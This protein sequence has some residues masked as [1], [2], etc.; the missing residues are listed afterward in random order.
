[1][2]RLSITVIMAIILLCGGSSFAAS[3]EEVINPFNPELEHNQRDISVLS[4]ADF[5][6]IWNAHDRN[7]LVPVLEWLH[8]FGSGLS[9]HVLPFSR[10]YVI[11]ITTLL[12]NGCRGNDDKRLVDAFLAI[13]VRPQPRGG[14]R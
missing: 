6:N 1:M 11:G 12:I 14:E 5:M 8:G 3:G 2:I 7:R 4:C 13:A 9:N 10:D